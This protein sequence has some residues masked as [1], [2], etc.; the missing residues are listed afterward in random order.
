MK[1]G[2]FKI[3]AV[4]STVGNWA[5]KAFADGKIDSKEAFEL[6]T[7]LAAVLGLPTDIK[8]PDDF[9]HGEL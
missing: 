2:F 3:F 6:V 1:I 8:L 9:T 4:V 5:T 7:E